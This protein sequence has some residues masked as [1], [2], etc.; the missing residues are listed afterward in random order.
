ML[1]WGYGMRK[2]HYHAGLDIGLQ[3]GD[4]VAAAFDGVVRFTGFKKKGYGNCVVIRHL[5]GLE[6]LYGHLS[7]ISVDSNQFVKAGQMLGLGGSSGK[8]TGPHLHFETRYQDVAFNPFLIIDSLTHQLRCDTITLYKKEIT[9]HP[10][11]TPKYKKGTGSYVPPKNANID[12][13]KI[14]QYYTVK[15]G[16]TI[17]GICSRYGLSQQ[18]LMKLN[19]L[20]SDKLQIGQKL[21][22]K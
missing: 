5:N 13:S 19:G 18:K 11:L 22:L 17:W 20:K 3:I 21:K 1:N 6:T 12:P 14:P 16:D 15:K 10:N 2:G 4:T 8:S 7:N 9:Y